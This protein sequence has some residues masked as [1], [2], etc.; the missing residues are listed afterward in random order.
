MKI[1]LV[2]TRHFLGGG[3]ATYTFNL[4]GLL[5]QHGHTVS[6]FAMQDQRNVPDPNEDLFVSNIDFRAE[7]RHKSLAGGVRVASR[8]IYSREAREKFGRLL[9][10]TRPDLVHLQSLHGHL[11]PSV[12]FE[13]QAQGLPVVWTLH[14][15]KLMCPNTSFMI[16]RTGQTCEACGTHAYYQPILK[17][18][19]KDSLLASGLASLEAYVHQWLGVRDRVDVFLAPSRFLY[20][21]LLSRGFDPADVYH[22]PNFLPDADL[23]R[24][25]SASEGYVLFLGRIEAT[26][27]MATLLEASRMAPNVRVVVA[28][29]ADEAAQRAW[30][31]HLPANVEYVG[32]LQGEALQRWLAGALAVVAPTICYENQPFSVLEAFARHKPVIASNL[33]G[34]TELVAHQERGLLVPPGEAEPLADAMRRLTAQPDKAQAMGEAA[35]RYVC[36]EHNASVHYTRL[37]ELYTRALAR[38]AA[39]RGVAT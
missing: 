24:P 12:I 31:S 15:Y 21:K 20:D 26:K 4:A 13:A 34:L 19:K 10:R 11:T 14:D 32:F 17:R 16:D 36:R 39:S 9:E 29:P 18:C 25:A 6:F 5:R 7:N 27:G 35:Y 33:G 2:N 28:G 23:A 3:D 8:V 30:L 38:Q 37:V 1:M 22:T